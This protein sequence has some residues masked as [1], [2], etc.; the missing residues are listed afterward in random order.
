[1]WLVCATNYCVF[2]WTSKRHLMPLTR[3]HSVLG[4]VCRGVP[5][6]GTS[7]ARAVLPQHVVKLGW[8]QGSKL[9]PQRRPGCLHRHDT[10]EK[11]TLSIMRHQKCHIMS[12]PL[13]TLFEEG[14]VMAM[15]EKEKQL[16]F[17]CVCFYITKL[18]LL[19]SH[20]N[21]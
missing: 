15:T 20:L 16:F 7:F 10:T 17:H 13:T 12:H 11:N 4:V 9:G 3:P 21:A 18:S 2:C 8:V 1:M 14:V 6:G 5:S 19:V